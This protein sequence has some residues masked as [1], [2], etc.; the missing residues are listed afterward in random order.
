MKIAL[1]ASICLL[2]SISAQATGADPERLVRIGHAAPISSAPGL[3][4]AA[5]DSERG[6][7]LAVDELNARVLRVGDENLHFELLRED[8]RA[9]SNTAIEVAKR[10]VDG[11]VVGV[12][13]HLNSGM[14]IKASDIYAAAGIPQITPAGTNPTFTRRGLKTTFRV[15]ADDNHVMQGF[16][17]YT[18]KTLGLHRVTILD[19][20]DDYSKDVTAP[21]SA[22]V[23]RAGGLI[24]SRASVDTKATDHAGLISKLAESNPDLIFFGGFDGVAGKLL[25]EMKQAGIT[26]A[27]A[28]PDALCSVELMKLSQNTAAQRKT[29]CAEAG[30]V[31]QDM[32]PRLDQFNADFF[33]KYSAKP[34]QYAKH[35]FDAV[36]VL[37][38][39]MLRAQSLDPVVYVRELAKTVAYPGVTGPISFDEKGDLV[40]G[41]ISIYTYGLNGRELLEVIH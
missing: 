12:V 25:I 16:G 35:S 22:G 9:N 11:K 24:V 8:D 29:V 41:M 28:G 38:D 7:Q 21:Y 27:F 26:A 37:V 40:N 19:T 34:L 4:P 6:A 39:A 17:Q 1:F 18:V 10:L 36:N 5:L 31:L 3:A 15:I 20:G 2:S 23:Q 14:S 32:Q 33:K 30:G 13:G